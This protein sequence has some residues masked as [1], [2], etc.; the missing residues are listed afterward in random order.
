MK[1]LLIGSLLLAAISAFGQVSVGISIGAPPPPRVLKVRPASPGPDFMWVDGYWY[2]V[3][4][5]YVWHQGYWTRAPYAG[6]HWVAPHHE[7]GKWFD[8]YWDGEHGRVRHDHAWDRERERDYH[9]DRDHEHE[10]DRH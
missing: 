9:H 2:P 10:H 1:R 8:G 7:E 3:N 4:G 6:A 5:R